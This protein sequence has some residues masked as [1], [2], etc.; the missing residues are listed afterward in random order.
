MSIS[1]SQSRLN[2]FITSTPASERRIS[3]L[4]EFS[5]VDLVKAFKT[6]CEHFELLNK[7]HSSLVEEFQHLENQIVPDDEF[8]GFLMH[9]LEG[10]EFIE[11]FCGR[12]GNGKIEGLKLEDLKEDIMSC[13]RIMDKLFSDIEELD[14]PGGLVAKGRVRHPGRVRPDPT[15]GQAPSG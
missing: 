8:M 1:T 11:A 12:T 2:A 5:Q 9:T 7:R 13:C 14:G 6:A 10:E 3:F 15:G 4:N